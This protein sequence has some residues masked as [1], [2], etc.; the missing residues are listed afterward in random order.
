MKNEINHNKAQHG[1]IAKRQRKK[2]S[3][4]IGKNIA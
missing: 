4:Q 3:K 2:Y 1:Q